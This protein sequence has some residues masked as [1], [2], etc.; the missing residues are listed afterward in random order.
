MY[1]VHRIMLMTTFLRVYASLTFDFF[2]T[3]T[4]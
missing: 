1:M 4:T 3:F 2:F